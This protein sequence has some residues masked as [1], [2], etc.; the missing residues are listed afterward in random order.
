MELS[1][2]RLER[3]DDGEVLYL[4]T[5][6]D[7]V[8]ARSEFPDELMTI[9]YDADGIVIGIEVIG[10]LARSATAGLL[11]AMTTAES[12]TNSSAVAAALGPALA[13]G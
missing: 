4:A 7:G 2:S 3:Y 5:N 12:V 1:E 6:P 13:A 10:P 8:W 11:H 9:D